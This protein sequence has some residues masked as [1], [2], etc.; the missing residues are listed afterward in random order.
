M[1]S[2]LELIVRPFQTGDVSP[3]RALLPATGTKSPVVK[4]QLGRAGGTKTFQGNISLS[5]TLYN[6][7]WPKETLSLDDTGRV[8]N[9]F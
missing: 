5:T 3:P 8:I 2:A 4:I 9:A 1:S 7:K 6:K